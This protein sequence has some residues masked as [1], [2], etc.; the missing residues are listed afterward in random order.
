MSTETPATRLEAD[1]RVVQ[2]R[3]FLPVFLLAYFAS[4]V[5]LLAA[6][7]VSIPLRLAELDPAH[8]TQVLSLTMALGGIAIIVVTPPLGHLSDTS[9]SRFGIRRPFLVGGTLVGAV[10]LT[11]LATAPTVGGVVAGWCITQ[12][13]FAA[14]LVVFN[15][16]LADQI[17]V[18]IRARVAAVFGIST[19]LAPVVGSVF[20]N[21]LP[22]DPRWW[23]GLPAVLAL[24]FNGAAVLVLRDIVRTE[25]V[26]RS[27]Q[28]ILAS[29]WMNPRKHQDFAW[30]WICRL[31]V[32]M[33][34]LLVTVYM[35]Y[36]VAGTLGLSEH[37]AA[38]K[39]GVIIGAF[40]I[41][42]T[43]TAAISAWWSDR[44]G[45]RKGIVWTSCLITA[46]GLVILLLFKD[47]HSLLLGA[48]VIGAGQ[49]AYAAVDLALMTEV[50]PETESSGKDLGVVAMAYLLPQLLVP[51]LAT[52]LFGLHHAQGDFSI[53]Y[54]ASMVL[55]VLGALAVL[56]IK[57]VR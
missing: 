26:P 46:V 16:L 35:L 49:G 9:I 38:A 53:L 19:S 28:A 37:E 27:W 18:A 50:L 33:S 34:V 22:N 32:T 30:A 36:I 2:P 31:F 8:K 56:P 12:I 13:G 24:M 44:T 51:M 3:A 17:S 1:V 29:Y 7:A 4:A 6:G 48:A 25:R 23:F 11:T 45:R 40:L 55:S 52:A 14:T 10:G 5:A 54:L 15:A 42:N 57:S 47:F 21:V 41:T 20:I 43:V 39:Y